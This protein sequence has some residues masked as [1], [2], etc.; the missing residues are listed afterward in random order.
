MPLP[1]CSQALAYQD[2]PCL[3]K[4][5]LGSGN[6]LIINHNK[7]DKKTEALRRKTTCP[8]PRNWQRQSQDS[9]P[10]LFNPKVQVLPAKWPCPGPARK[11]SVAP[12]RLTQAGSPDSFFSLLSALSTPWAL[13]G[14]QLCL[15]S[16]PFFITIFITTIPCLL[17]LANSYSYFKT[18]KE[19]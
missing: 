17:L 1:E 19:M 11:E 10:S 2:D 13:R 16:L 8:V 9:I 6:S 14:M 5:P 15:F 12:V 7:Q 4:N 18:P 3:W